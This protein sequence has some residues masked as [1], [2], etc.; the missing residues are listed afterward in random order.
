MAGVAHIDQENGQQITP[1]VVIALEASYNIHPNGIHS[2]Y[3]SIGS[4]KATVFQ[5]GTA[6]DVT[7][8]KP[9]QAA[10]LSFTGADGE[11]FALN[12][13]QTWITAIAPNRISFTL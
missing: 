2:Q 13:G 9:T 7:W 6:T 8:S 5:D 10:A 4:G 3:G 11:S 1:K 12:P